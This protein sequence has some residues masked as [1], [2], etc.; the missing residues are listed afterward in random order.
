MKSFLALL[1]ILFVS[2]FGIKAQPD[3]NNIKR[4]KM[5]GIKPNNTN[6]NLSPKE[7]NDTTIVYKIQNRMISAKADTNDISS[8]KTADNVGGNT[9]AKKPFRL[10]QLRPRQ[11]LFLGLIIPSA[12][13]IYNKK[14]WKLPI[15]YT[16]LAGVTY[17][18]YD[19][20]INY[21][22]YRRAYLYA[23]DNNPLTTGPSGNAA[24]LKSNRERYQNLYERSLLIGM[25]VYA[26][27]AIDGFVDAH[28]KTFEVNDNLSLKIQPKFWN[29]D[30]LTPQ[31]ATNSTQNSSLNF[32]QPTLS[33]K[34]SF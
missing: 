10:D 13:Q 9:I 23:V 26:L 31:I 33:L 27:I 22:K 5:S 8:E 16:A 25:G 14:W 7:D 34:F 30:N 11:V 18:V 2:I 28:L 3:T 12:G 29:M 19:N 1:I 4:G 6:N 32:I 21:L 20:R 15:V 24:N 17:W